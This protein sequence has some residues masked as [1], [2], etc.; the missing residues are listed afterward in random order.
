MSSGFPHAGQGTSLP[1][2][3]SWAMNFWPQPQATGKGIRVTHLFE[4]W[5]FERWL[6]QAVASY[7][8]LPRLFNQNGEIFTHSRTSPGTASRSRLSTL[9]ARSRS[10]AIA[11]I[12]A[13]SVH[14]AGGAM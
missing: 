6:E 12:T 14:I 13:L 8:I 2:R 9:P 11:P 3:W 10:K 7:S 1:E 5:S 4:V